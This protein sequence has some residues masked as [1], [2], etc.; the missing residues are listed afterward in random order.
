MKVSGETKRS[1]YDK[2]VELV[3][4]DYSSRDHSIDIALNRLYVGACSYK[5]MKE[6]NLWTYWQGDLN[7]KILV[8]G[9]DWGSFHTGKAG[10]ELDNRMLQNLKKMDAGIS[11]FYFDGI[12]KKMRSTTDNNLIKLMKELG[13]DIENKRIEGLFFSNLCLGYRNEGYSGGFKQ[14]WL[15][16]DAKYLTGFDLGGGHIAGLLEIIRPLLVIC[17]GKEVYKVTR[18]ALGNPISEKELKDF[19]YNLDK[20]EKGNEG[21]NFVDCY[22]NGHKLRVYGVSHPG[23]MGIANRRAKSVKEKGLSGLDLQ[24]HD[25]RKI[26]EYLSV[27]DLTYQN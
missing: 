13:Y 3:K 21:G 2:L 4:E 9:Q 11:S 26:G 7:A 17:L 19:Y 8:L 27:K 1:A 25:W 6:I 23:G 12:P 18:N 16:D 10:R 24:L 22:F 5:D 14:K 15:T 20:E